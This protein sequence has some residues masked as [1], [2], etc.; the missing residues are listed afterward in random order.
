MS[1]MLAEDDTVIPAEGA[2]EYAERTGADVSTCEG[3]HGSTDCYSADA[4]LALLSS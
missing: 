4:V 2:R 1:V 3:D